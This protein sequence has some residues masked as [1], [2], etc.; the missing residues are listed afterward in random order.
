M[1]MNHRGFIV[2]GVV[3]NITDEIHL[4]PWMIQLNWY[5][6]KWL[7]YRRRRKLCERLLERIRPYNYLLSFVQ[8]F[9]MYCYRSIKRIVCLQINRVVAHIRA[10]ET[11]F[12]LIETFK[13]N[14]SS[15]FRMDCTMYDVHE[16]FLFFPRF[17]DKKRIRLFDGIH[18][19]YVFACHT[20]FPHYSNVIPFYF[21]LCIHLH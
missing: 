1:P 17:F 10:Q 2:A 4:F 11:A 5:G 16:T 8:L 14:L 21:M 9:N 12:P 13:L 19:H 6:L 3:H 7:L 20:T 18:T 15:R